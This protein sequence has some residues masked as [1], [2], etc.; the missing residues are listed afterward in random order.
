MP[1]QKP[2]KS[3][4]EIGTPPEFITA[5]ARK[6]GLWGE[7]FTFDIAATG[8]VNNVAVRFFSKADD[9]LVKDWPTEGQNWLNPEFDDIAPWVKK[10]YM[11]GRLGASTAVLV[12]ASTGAN[13]WKLWVDQKAHILQLNGRINFIGYPDAYPKD[14][15]LLLY[16]PGIEPM[17]EVWTWMDELT[18]DETKMAKTRIKAAKQ[19]KAPKG[20]N[21]REFKKKAPKAVKTSGGDLPAPIQTITAQA[22]DVLLPSPEDSVRLLAE[23]AAINDLVSVAKQTHEDLKERTKTAKE[24]Y[25]ELAERLLTRLRVAT[26]KSDLPL[27]SLDEREADQRRMEESQKANGAAGTATEGPQGDE[28]QPGNTEVPPQTTEPP[29]EAPIASGA[30]SEAF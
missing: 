11:Q 27:F 14:C 2:G 22:S 29:T 8:G 4:Q 13:W 7:R 15:A 25:D 6:L 24:K 16:G 12:P 10:A 28:R 23:L 30:D 21:V 20:D 1:K 26:H 18:E 5:A 9:A 17:S 3:D 19:A